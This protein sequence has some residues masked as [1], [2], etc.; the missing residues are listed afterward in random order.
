[1][2]SLSQT[3]VTL[4]V[5]Y[6]NGELDGIEESIHGAA[7]QMQ[8][9]RDMDCDRVQAVEIIAPSAVAWKAA[10]SMDSFQIS[11]HS[12][13]RKALAKLNAVELL[14]ARFVSCDSL[15][16]RINAL[17]T[18]MTLCDRQRLDAH[19]YSRALSF[20]LNLDLPANLDSY[21]LSCAAYNQVSAAINSSKTRELLFRL[22]ELGA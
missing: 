16:R 21:A 12:F 3:L 4:Y 14:S 8:D 19:D 20:T 1:M 10:E 22:I 5:I 7:R 6:A 11:S 13:G 17:A 15:D 18:I 9:L 2:T